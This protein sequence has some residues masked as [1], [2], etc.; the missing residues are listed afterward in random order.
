MSMF[1]FLSVVSMMLTLP[2]FCF[3]QAPPSPVPAYNPGFQYPPQQMM[4][5]N[6]GR[7]INPMSQAVS[8]GAMGTAQAAPMATQ[9]RSPMAPAPAATAGVNN[10]LSD[11]GT[12]GAPM[13][14]PMDAYAVGGQSYFNAG[15]CGV[16]GC[17][18]S[19]MDGGC[20]DSDG[21]CAGRYFSVFGGLADLDSQRSTGFNRNLLV[22]FDEGYALGGALG[23]RVG[24]FF[25]TE[26][27]YC[28]RSQDPGNVIFNGNNFQNLSG[29]QNSHTGMYNLFFD[30]IIGH[31]NLVPYIGGGVGVGF[32]DSN[33]DFGPGELDGD[34][35]ALALQWM[36]GLSYRARPNMEIFVEYRFFEMED[37]KLNYFGAPPIGFQTPNILL[38]SEYQST[39][40]FA[41]FRFNF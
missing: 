39:D 19:G 24:R 6:Y 21:S 23:R 4:P 17:D 25:R 8:P 41:G 35:T 18:S 12:W 14:A 13:M 20:C 3:G 29:N 28:Y 2:V 15:D 16:N 33:I 9:T 10:T 1:R 31:G 26:L 7:Y 37:P 11:C 34:D 30:M 27:E 5:A 38:N 36:A 40:V 32:I 22:A